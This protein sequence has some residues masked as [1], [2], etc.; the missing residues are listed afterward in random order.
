MIAR[1]RRHKAHIIVALGGVARAESAQALA[2]ASMW[3]SHDNVVLREG[4]YYDEELIGCRIVQAGRELGVVRAVHHYPAQDVLEL[5]RGALVPMVSAFVRNVDLG[6]RVIDV[7]LPLGL[8][9][10]EPL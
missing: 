1:A 6:A 8:V 10:G 4:E 7:D 9:E 2:G 3:T 5:E